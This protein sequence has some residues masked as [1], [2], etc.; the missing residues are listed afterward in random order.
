MAVIISKINQSGGADYTTLQ[1]WFN[2]LPNPLT[3]SGGN[4]YQAS[5]QGTLSGTGVL[6]DTSGNSMNASNY[7]IVTS[8]TGQGF[9][10]NAGVRTNALAYNATNGAA[11]T[12]SSGTATITFFAAYSF[13]QDLQIQNTG[14]GKT[15]YLTGGLNNTIADSIIDGNN[16][17]FTG[18]IQ[19]SDTTTAIYRCLAINRAGSGNRVIYNTSNGSSYIGCTFAVPSDAAGKPDAVVYYDTGAASATQENCAIYGGTAAYGGSGT[20]PT[21][22]NCMTDAT[23]TTGLTGS[24]TYANQFVNTTT[25]SQDWREKN[26]SANLYGAGVQDSTNDAV[27]I[28]GTTR[29]APP[30]IGAWEILNPASIWV[31]SLR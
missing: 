8:D 31:Y 24:T 16:S 21:F 11:I 6:L 5:V 25:S 7:I 23:G 9:R 4:V 19:D 26:S 29:K 27:D 3:G 30:D 1:A 2:A 13:I 22:T 10:D 14:G 17:S 15:I 28:T 20:T 18:V 12:S